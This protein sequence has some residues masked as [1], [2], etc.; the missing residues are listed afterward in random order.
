MRVC[1]HPCMFVRACACTCA[2]VRVCVRVEVQP[3]GS[4]RYVCGRARARGLQVPPL[5]P[6]ASPSMK[7]PRAPSPPRSR[8][9][10]LNPHRGS[11]G[12]PFMNSMMGLEA[13]SALTRSATGWAPAWAGACCCGAASVGAGAEERAA[14]AG[15][16]VAGAAGAEA[17]AA[18]SSPAVGRLGGL[19]LG[20]ERT[21][22]RG[23]AD[24]GA[25]TL[26]ANGSEWWGRLR[27]WGRGSA[28]SS[29]GSAQSGWA[30]DLGPL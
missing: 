25:T 17:R 2:C 23:W 4:C 12:S 26:T 8:T 13:S 1:M 7:T 28:L 29:R 16:A 11:A 14:A 10:R 30:V 9:L 3:V 20:V 6:P 18:F 15:A 5:P 22:A 24:V 27:P 19:R 21:A